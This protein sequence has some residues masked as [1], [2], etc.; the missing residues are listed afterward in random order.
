M[1]GQPEKRMESI[2]TAKKDSATKQA[3]ISA[4]KQSSLLANDAFKKSD[5]LNPFATASEESKHI[6]TIVFKSKETPNDAV[7]HYDE[8]HLDKHKD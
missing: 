8:D 5:Q 6:E 1:T 3:K 4:A 7:M 2:F